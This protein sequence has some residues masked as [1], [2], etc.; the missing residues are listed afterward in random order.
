MKT[1][2]LMRATRRARPAI[3]AS[4]FSAAY[5]A[6]C[7]SSSIRLISPHSSAKGD[8]KPKNPPAYVMRKSSSKRNGTPRNKLPN[9]TPKISGGTTPVMVSD[10]SQ[11]LHHCGFM[12]LLR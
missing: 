7:I 12:D 10:Q 9:A 6:P 3:T 4:A 5:A 11:A 1:S 8:S 2:A